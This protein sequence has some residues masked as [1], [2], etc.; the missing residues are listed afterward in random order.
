MHEPAHGRWQVDAEE[1]HDRHQD[2]DG[3]DGPHAVPEPVRL[4]L[5]RFAL[6]DRQQFAAQELGC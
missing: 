6:Y 1:Q 2:H 4:P 5:G 3:G